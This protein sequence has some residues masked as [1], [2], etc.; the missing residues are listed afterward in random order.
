MVRIP[1]DM[2]LGQWRSQGLPGWASRPPAHPEDQNE[3]ENEE[4]LRK[5]ERIYRKIRRDWG[6]VFL[7]CPPGSESLATALFYQRVKRKRRDFH[8][9]KMWMI[10][11]QLSIDV[12]FFLDD[13]S[14]RCCCI[15]KCKNYRFVVW[16]L[17]VKC[18]SHASLS[19]LFSICSIHTRQLACNTLNFSVL[20]HVVLTF[21]KHQGN[22]DFKIKLL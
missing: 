1:R 2:L 10:L 12:F 21:W 22:V 3:E 9:R 14:R 4:N 11:K 18:N 20:I 7:S 19:G 5:N 13:R 8:T 6:N 17:I 15:W 16:A